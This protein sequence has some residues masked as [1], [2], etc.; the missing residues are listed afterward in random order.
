MSARLALFDLDGTLLRGPSSERRFAAW[1]FGRRHAG[2]AQAGAWLAYAAVHARRDGRHVLRRDK[3]YVAGL[4]VGL[5][6]ELAAAHV[7]AVIGAGQVDPRAHAALETHRRAGDRCVLLSGTLQPLADAYAVRLGLGLDA[8]IG[9]L[10]PVRGGRYALGPPAR[11][12]YGAAKRTLAERERAACGVDP[13]DTVAYG[14]SVADRNVLGW[15]GEAVAV[16]PDRAL[17]A[18]A[19]ERGWRVLRHARGPAPVPAAV[20]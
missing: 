6:A 15:A 11:H 4:G 17:A 12:P 18:L 13:T 16:E 1:L 19:R 9:S 14:D 5:V 3:G 10:A 2:A 7:D 8:A 20:V